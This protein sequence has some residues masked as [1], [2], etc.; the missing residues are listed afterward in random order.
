M[1]KKLMK[2][3]KVCMAMMATMMTVQPLSLLSVQAADTP[4][5]TKGSLDIAMNLSL[6][7]N[8]KTFSVSLD[9]AEK[10]EMQVNEN[11]TKAAVSFKDMT[12]GKYTLKIEAEGYIPYT[13]E[14]TIVQG[15]TTSVELHNNQQINNNLPNADK[16]HG[17]MAVGDINNDGKIDKADADQM[18]DAIDAG[19][20]DDKYDLNGDKKVNVTDLTYI[21]MNYGTN[22]TATPLT[23]LSANTIT[24]DKPDESKVTVNGDLTDLAENTDAFVQFKP[25]SGEISEQNP[26]QVSL[27]VNGEGNA[28][29]KVDGIV[30]KPPVNTANV[31]DKGSVFVETA[32]GETIEVDIIKYDDQQLQLAARAAATATIESDGTVVVNLGEQIA[33]KTV[34][35]KVT[36]SSTNLV[37][38][39]QVEFV[40][41]MENRIP[42][43]EL[44]IPTGVEINQVSTGMNPSF[45]VSWKAQPNVT[46]YEVMVSGNG[47][48]T[49]TATTNTSLKVTSLNGKLST[50]VPY[51]VRVRSTNGDWK[52]PYS[53]SQTVTIKP[54]AAPPAPE[55]VS[56][57]GNVQSI[58]VKWKKMQDTKT[59]S[60]FYREQNKGDYKEIPGITT[61]NYTITE[62]TPGVKYQVYV[63]GY[64]EHGSSKPSTVNVA[65]PI[66]ATA[67]KMP[68]YDLINTSNGTG[69]KTNHVVSVETRAETQ[70][71]GSEFAVVDDDPS[72]YTRVHDWDTGF[73]GT[74]FANPIVTLD[75]EY[76]LQTIR[77]TTHVSQKSPYK[78]GEAAVRY[79]D[80]N[81]NTMQK[82]NGQ[83]LIR[84]DAAGKSY[85]E[86]Q[87]QQPVTSNK[88]Q[89][90]LVTADNGRDVSIAEMNFY[91]YD[92]LEHDINAL[93]EDNLH[94]T[95]KDTVKEET[96]AA[97]EKR[98]DIPDTISG[99]YHPYRESLKKE[100]ENARL[101][102]NQQGL[103]KP[104]AVDTSVTPK[105]D[106]HIEFGYAI[107]EYQP[108]GKVA[109]AGETVI[110][111]VGSDTEKE[112]TS[113]PLSFVATQNHAEWSNWMKAQQLKIGRN[114]IKIPEIATKENE[115][116]GS[117]YVAWTGP[118]NTNAKYSIRV[119]GGQD[120]PMLNVSGKTG[121]A[122]K[123]AIS[124]YVAALKDHVS[125]LNT[126]HTAQHTDSAYNERE[127]ILNYT[128]I[129]MDNMM[130]SVPATQV[131]AGIEK[132][133]NPEEALAQAIAAMEQEMDLFYQHKGMHK[134]KTATNDADR[135]PKQRL[136]IRYHQMFAGAFMYAGGKHIGIEYGS[137]PDLFSI[138]PIETNANGTQSAGR[139]TG[140]GIAHEI[141]HVINNKH[142]AT[143]EITNNYYAILST[144]NPRADYNKVYDMV[145]GSGGDAGLQMSMYWQLHMF[146]DKYDNYKIFDTPEE[147]K[148]NLFF[149]RVDSYSRNTASAPKA[150]QN[151]IA[152]TLTNNKSDN[153]IRLSCAAA[154]KNLLPFFEAWGL[155]Y[156]ADTAK[157]A[158]QFPKETHKIQYMHPDAQKYRLA[159]NTGM[160]EGTTVAADTTYVD[161]KNTVT[162]T[163]DNSDKSDAMLGY[164]ILRN[165]KAVA[166]VPASETSYVDT[167]TTGNNRTYTYEVI[168]YDK[169]LNATATKTLAP[170][171]VKH[172]GAIDRSHWTITTN[173]TSAD[174]QSITPDEENGYCKPTTISAI[175]RIIDGKGQVYTGNAPDKGNAEFIIDLGKTEQVTALKYKGESADFTISVSKDGQ[176]WTE[177]KRGTFTG[178]EQ[179]QTVYFDQAEQPNYMFIY[180]AAFVKVTFDTVPA[181]IADVNILGPTSDNVELLENGV[182]KLKTAF[183]YGKKPEQVIPEGSAVFTGTYKG[184]P[185]Y[186][187]VLLKDEKGKIVEGSQI[188]MATDPQD[189]QLGNVSDGTWIYWIEPKD[190]ARLPAG[191]VKAELYRVDDAQTN[192]N[193]RLVS[194]TLYINVPAALPDLELQGGVAPLNI[195]EEMKELVP[196]TPHEGEA[197]NNTDQNTQ[198]DAST[199]NTE[200]G[201]ENQNTDETT[202]DAPTESTENQTATD[203]PETNAAENIVD[204]TVVNDKKHTGS[205]P[206]RRGFR[207]VAVSGTV[208]RQGT[209]KADANDKPHFSFEMDT[210]NANKAVMA[211]HL[212][213]A[214]AEK[215]IAL[216]TSF[217]VSDENIT[218]VVMDWSDI[219]QNR[220]LLKEC[221]YD[222]D[223]KI[224]TLYVTAN[225]DLLDSGV[226]T[227]GE[228]SMKAT[229]NT[230]TATLTLKPDSTI[231]VNTAF[232]GNDVVDLTGGVELETQNN[233]GSSGGSSHR[234][235][236]GGSDNKPN[237][238]KTEN[239]EQTQK[240]AE[241]PA[242]DAAAVF[243]DIQKGAWYY[244]AVQRAYEKSWFKGTSA[245]EFT[246][247]GTMTRGMFVTVLGRFAGA[248]GTPNSKFTDVAADKYYAGFVAW[249]AEQGIVSGV[250]ENKF[251]P[252]ASITRE[253]LAVMVYGY[254][255]SAGVELDTTNAKKTFADDA[256]ISKWANEAVYAMQ[257]SGLM[258]GMPDG[259]F[260]PKGTATRAEVAT[261]MMHLESKIQK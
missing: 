106:N 66:T 227:L 68:K 228:I 234:P 249:A 137:V 95:L 214:N 238:D 21:T 60:V 206:L 98:V 62:L 150:A 28:V 220:A 99:E 115:N 151:G 25:T 190:M 160:A 16:K 147:Q 168:A 153:L 209:V 158:Q 57:T 166:F 129:V 231:T 193:A 58:L 64:N 181:S 132:Q 82:M 71:I 243:H 239:T 55:N 87:L 237:T 1:K 186:N 172:D 255:R 93:Y 50:Y 38:I 74:N 8:G 23:I 47:K 19:K 196:A 174:D 223:K 97:L 182:G 41:G 165:G 79:F 226:M 197:E 194:D 12:P 120:I 131:L 121:D 134:T 212:G 61:N 222:K 109:K 123:Q 15:V 233:G 75:Q 148:E 159:G 34:T 178:G 39:A 72:T 46:G 191:R 144:G 73:Y 229:G 81:T 204:E 105:A 122:R 14:V 24:V 114:E 84:K 251:A 89:L 117:L 101:L 188:I 248:T 200:N 10:T 51:T 110:V 240:P 80:K 208:I 65:T 169:L 232:E 161:G 133:Q 156:D 189:G 164:E 145:T 155:T 59:Y 112:G 154:E 126:E 201:N 167:I 171:K 128:D 102:L 230:K 202:S 211:L 90:C 107:S 170:I 207:N 176:T 17:V 2:S 94:L 48:Q 6:P 100:L 40:N 67:V 258:S 33:I 11:G 35:I 236:H 213:D 177:A 261:I 108:L 54:D 20:T 210:D 76:K 179:E 124:E 224:V 70:I 187:V 85:F 252:E 130:Y 138:R 185:A 43:P 13:Q 199:D 162:L 235:S 77:F 244:N 140:W 127:C 96:I 18:M 149:A 125:K 242:S 86:M 253:Q 225:Q 198:G 157:Y 56:V 22:V 215:T 256:K 195:V 219:I 203:T 245:T 103:G 119:S 136:N 135:Y 259:S 69:T 152:L 141:G 91:K 53:E 92:M 78:T 3:K 183:Q 4:S 63:V 9:D 250:S 30:I 217:T 49:V 192:E 26:V 116:G 216:Q 184:H 218:D 247:N 113:I 163:L 118:A 173:M 143:A 104:I 44:N 52:S 146:Y 175:S 45:T 42:E 27:H 32:T 83:L 36:G 205:A 139:L 221:R 88:F 37:D 260:Q 111:Y 31:I 257:Q 142:Y 7:T 29:P 5:V 246:P 180:D 254:L 241:T